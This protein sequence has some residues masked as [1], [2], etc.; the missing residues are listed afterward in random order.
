MGD[1]FSL[2]LWG[3]LRLFD[4]NGVDRTPRAAKE[5][6]LLAILALA[7]GRP[8]AR[9]A[10]QDKLWSDRDQARGRDSLK[11]ALSGLR[12]AFGPTAGDVL[13]CEGQT[14]RLRIDRLSIDV[15]EL[16]AQ[17]RGSKLSRPSVLEG[18]A[19]RDQQFEEWL[20]DARAEFDVDANPS[21][22][23]DLWA[24]SQPTRLSLG[25]QTSVEVETGQR[26]R[27][28]ANLLLDRTIEAL[29]LS[30]HLALHDFREVCSEGSRAI[31]AKLTVKAIAID[32]A[33]RVGFSLIRVVDSRLLWSRHEVL[34]PRTLIADRIDVFV[35]EASDQILHSL[36]QR[37]A[38]GDYEKLIA[39]RHAIDGID[40]ML[41]LAPTDLS[42]AREALTIAIEA[43]PKSTYVGWLAY[44]SAFRL[45]EAKGANGDALRDEVDDLKARALE[46]DRYNP[47]TRALFTHVYGFVFRDF[48]HAAALI[49]P[50]EGKPCDLA[51]VH[52]SLASLRCYVG[53]FNNALVSAYRSRRL[54]RM[55]P[56]AYAFSTAVCMV[57]AARGNA[58][59]A[60]RYGEE[61][62]AL[63]VGARR[64]FEPTLRYLA[65]AYSE[66]GDRSNGVRIWR[67]IQSQSPQF[68]SR[69][70]EDE[71]FPVPSS[72]IRLRMHQAFSDIGRI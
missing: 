12:A 37:D 45:E 65:L 5:Q 2:S 34:A 70:L 14:V 48:A 39:A 4:S 16:G 44:L 21:V 58:A 17:A 60:V 1:I 66:A 11:K 25:V 69:S 40:R 68:S 13:C 8:M 18:I 54:G 15:F 63:Q 67:R 9:A 71:R 22:V 20:R 29:A 10:L 6:G 52:H 23:P 36:F 7:R 61:G 32:G 62:L 27:D 26:A 49:E 31:D 41:R 51:L 56:Y 59:A 47:L 35:A 33:I 43:D 19:I 28:L 24:G 64:A 30:Q 72:A 55:N 3:P 46:I 38:L 42:A 57:E 50:V 53:D